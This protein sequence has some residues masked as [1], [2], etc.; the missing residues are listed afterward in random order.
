MGGGDVG[1][2]P[3]LAL[4][5]RLKLGVGVRGEGVDEVRAGG[6]R[7]VYVDGGDSVDEEIEVKADAEGGVANGFG[8]PFAKGDGE[9]DL[10]ILTAM[11][12]MKV[13]ADAEKIASFRPA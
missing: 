9:R 4:R 12:L 2:T 3:G 10:M 13:N 6:G 5:L 1:A 7:E 11:T 8:A